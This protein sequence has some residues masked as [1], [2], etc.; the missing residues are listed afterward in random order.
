MN[1]SMQSQWGPW[2]LVLAVAGGVVA[3]SSSTSSQADGGAPGVDG[4][5]PQ[6]DGGTPSG[7]PPAD[8]GP[9]GG[10]DTGAPNL[11]ASCSPGAMPTTIAG[12]WDV[13]GSQANATPST[14]LLVIDDSHFTFA[15]TRGASLTFSAQGGAMTLVWQDDQGALPITTTHTGTALAQGIIPLNLGGTW[16]FVNGSSGCHADIGVSQFSASCTGGVVDLPE[17]LPESLDGTV[18][19]QRVST[20]SSVFGDLGGTWHIPLASGATGDATFSGNTL[21]VV[22]KGEPWGDGTASLSFCDGIASGGTSEG[23]EF[24]AHRR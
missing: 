15:A 2:G 8:G 9:G 1:A 21:T 16:T 22:W 5:S 18:T 12:T 3:C 13:Q 23:V 14:S 11:G 10:A 20:A 19:G 7:T 6:A 17:P 24:S 4:A